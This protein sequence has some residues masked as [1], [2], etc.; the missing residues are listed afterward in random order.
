[1]ELFKGIRQFIGR[2]IMISRTSRLRRNKRFNNLHNAHKIAL[3][4]SAENED[5]LAIINNFY[6][7]MQKREVQT[8]IICYYPGHILPDNLTALRH[9][10]CFKL[11]DLN[12]IYIPVSPGIIEFINTPYEI[13]I[14]INFENHFPLQW[15]TALSVAELKIG[16]VDAGNSYLMDMTFDLNEKKETAYYLDQVKRYLEMINTTL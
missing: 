9:I 1:M 5:D 16:T 12:Y 2:K 14:D 4:W 13:L 7:E 8:D 11:S 15:I 10:N 3:V 6:R